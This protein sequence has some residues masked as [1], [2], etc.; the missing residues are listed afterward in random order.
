MAGNV[1]AE[2]ERTIGGLL[3][4]VPGYRGYRTKED[5]RDADRR[6]RDHLV[7]AYSSQADRVERVARDLANQR[8]LAEIGPVDEFARTLRHFIDRVRTATYGYGGL[9]GDRDVDAAALDQ[10]RQFDEGL[11][12]GVD[13][14][15]APIADLER[16][17]AAGG[18]LAA[19][20]RAGSE[21]VRRLLARFD[22]RG[23][24][25]ETGKPAPAESVLRVLE[26][27]RAEG[28][29]P[30]YNLR[31]GEAL[32]IHGDDFLVDG[33]VAVDGGPVSFRLLRLSGGRDEWLFVPATVEQGLARLT[34]VA[35][36][37]TG[38]ETTIG[39]TTYMPQVSGSG[40]G[41][42]SGV[43][44]RS[45]ARPVRYSLLAGAADAA[46]RAVILDWGT[47]RQAMAGREVHPDDVEVFGRPSPRL[48]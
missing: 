29:P 45:G 2:A 33:R 43:G 4:R 40:D 34:A 16:A 12:S 47:E 3:D 5:R 42:V 46:A 36:P 32:A 24:V 11:L 27:A 37:A 26:P 14:L 9:F 44:G 1:E 28:P 13:E 19:P 7:A 21:V 25:V 30:A 41:E 48:N 15:N 23:E 22:L 6:V 20:A 39:G 31:E 17:Y 18:D 8:R 38:T 10:L 35:A